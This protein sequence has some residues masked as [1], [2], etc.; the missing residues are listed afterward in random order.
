M[1]RI[2]HLSS[3]YFCSKNHQRGLEISSPTSKNFSAQRVTKIAEN[4]DLGTQIICLLFSIWT[5]FR[6]PRIS[7]ISSFFRKGCPKWTPLR[8]ALHIALFKRVNDSFT[9]SLGG[10]YGSLGAIIRTVDQQCAIALFAA[11]STFPAKHVIANPS[12][13]VQKQRPFLFDFFRHFWHSSTSFL[14]IKTA[15]QV[16]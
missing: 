4:G 7:Y 15:R 10:I 6:K 11:I 13:L 14:K 2:F 9:A 16:S 1:Y 3:C 8:A 12:S 5:F